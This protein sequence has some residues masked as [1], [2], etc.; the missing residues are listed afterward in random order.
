MVGGERLGAKSPAV[1]SLSPLQHCICVHLSVRL[2]GPIWREKTEVRLGANKKVSLPAGNGE[3]DER[4]TSAECGSKRPPHSSVYI[5][6]V[7]VFQDS[8]KDFSPT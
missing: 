8:K 7:A 3:G 1:Q 4:V 6:A 5:T 2:S